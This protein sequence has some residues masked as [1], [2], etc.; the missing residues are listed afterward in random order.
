MFEP[1]TEHFII[2]WWDCRKR[3]LSESRCGM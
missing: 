1:G 2:T 3:G